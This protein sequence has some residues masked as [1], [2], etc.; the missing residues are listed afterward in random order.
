MVAK[1]EAGAPALSG[2]EGNGLDLA[3]V[4]RWARAELDRRNAAREQVLRWSRELIRTCA[5]SIRAVHR[6]ELAAAAELLE[7]ARALNRRI[8]E[9]SGDLG[10]I[11][12]AGYVQDAQ[13]ELVEASAT[14][15]LLAG[16]P[17]P[18]P[19]ELGVA[20]GPFL[21][22]LAEAVGELR[23]YLLDRLRRGEVDGCEPLLAA[24]D[25]IYALLVMLDYPEALTGGLRRSTDV[26]RGILEK[27]RGDLTLAIRQ[28]AL[29]RRL[30]AV[31]TYNEPAG[32]VV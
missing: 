30:G 31:I 8:A 27:T 11:Y 28:E 2:G 13:K 5:T 1:P 23:R 19:A 16:R 7:T 32:P 4:E 6:R 26:A 15:A 9:A 18:E 10:E 22:G 3:R 14:Y 20:P 12:W 24:M 17:L 21:N 29:A 25:D